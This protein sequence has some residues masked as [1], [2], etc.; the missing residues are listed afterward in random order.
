[1]KDA[2]E[3]IAQA[4]TALGWE[5]E[6]EELERMRATVEEGSF[7]VAFLGQYSAGKSCLINHLLGRELLPHGVRETTALLT[8]LRYGTKE[9]AVLHYYGGR[10]RVL[11]LEEARSVQQ[12][13]G[14]D[15][16]QLEYME[17]FVESP[18]LQGGMILMDTPGINT[19][20][21]R[22]EKLLGRS[23]A[24]AAKAVYVMG[25]SPSQVDVKL[26]KGL[27]SRGIA[28]A[29]VRTHFD[30]IAQS[31]EDP[32][33]TRQ[34]DRSTLT[35]CGVAAEDCWFISNDPQSEYYGEVK[36]LQQMLALV[37]S[38]AQQ[39]LE[40]AAWAR[41]TALAEACTAE[42]EER[43][44]LLKPVCDEDSAKVEQAR[45]AMDQQIQKLEQSAK[46]WKK[47][48]DQ[49]V[50]NA[51]CKLKKNGP[52]AGQMKE[53]LAASAG[54]V[55]NSAVEKVEEMDA[56]IHDE[57]R[58]VMWQLYQAAENVC[59]EVLDNSSEAINQG[60][61]GLALRELPACDLDDVQVQQDEEQMEL[62]E[63]LR[64]IT[65]SK[66][67]LAQAI[68]EMND[69][70]RARLQEELRQ[71]EQQFMQ[72]QQ[73]YRGMGSYHP[74][75]LEVEDG[76]MQPSQIA[77]MVGTAADWALLLLPG[78]QIAAGLEKVLGLLKNSS[79][80]AIGI[81]IAEKVGK[82]ISKGDSI[83]DVTYALSH[84]SKTYATARRVKKA[85]QIVDAVADGAGKVVNAGRAI[86][87]AVPKEEGGLL[88]MLTISYWAK[89]AFSGLDRPPAQV[90]D[91]EYKTQYKQE[92]QRLRTE[93][94]ASQMK[95]FQ[96]KRDAQL[97]KSKAEAMEAERRA[98]ILEEKKVRAEMAKREEKLRQQAQ[99]KALEDWRKAC[100]Q[101]YRSRFELQLENILDEMSETLPAQV[102]HYQRE[103][104]AAVQQ[105]LQGKQAQYHAL[106]SAPPSEAQAQ[107]DQVNGLLKGLQTV[108]EHG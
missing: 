58:R 94:L 40:E 39:Q 64:Q 55:E 8:Y 7:F 25:G 79:G 56:L 42:L 18:L 67:Q 60:L 41:L 74:R 11:T 70:D 106:L 45:Q 85:G 50:E 16:E 2:F 26:L 99:K 36:P 49:E 21:E 23:L 10:Q 52:V 87:G 108:M 96:K 78:P 61:K 71:L 107:L 104:L 46:E 32:E 84:L 1:M 15:L 101:W 51:R 30:L 66:E 81:G 73:E 38:N 17:L 80:M 33:T 98:N 103:R 75:M 19:N 57:A 76:R 53:N 31:E 102:G 28:T 24:Q 82:I 3:K 65:E 14:Q 91:L 5:E 100:A 20:I 68:Q 83:K 69:T 35:D 34:S 37:G 97:F 59:G 44:A 89:K 6:R 27:V 63:K 95:I 92:E 93:M 62:A 48:L 72:A 4:M 13:G 29:C 47:K 43:R 86:K 90:E 22:H 77:G 12:Q 105:R 9:Q 88:D 54:R